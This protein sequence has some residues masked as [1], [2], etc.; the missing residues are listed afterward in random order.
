MR[1]ERLYLNGGLLQQ[2]IADRLGIS[3]RTLSRLIYRHTRSNFSRFVN[4]YRLQEAL[5]LLAQPQYR[6]L[7]IEQIGQK[8]GFNS[9]GVFH[10]VF[11]E[12]TGSSPAEY[13][14]GKK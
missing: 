11:R 4:A 9:R 12:E 14:A 3:S 7:S 6:H 2:Q 10:R 13:R 1:R 5:R 8:A